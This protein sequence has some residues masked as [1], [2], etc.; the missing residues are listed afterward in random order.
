MPQTHLSAADFRRFLHSSRRVG[1]LV[2]VA[3]VVAVALLAAGAWA[4][5]QA[6]ENHRRTADEALRDQATYLAGMIASGI[7]NNGWFAGRTLLRAWDETLHNGGPWPATDSI[8]ARAAREAIGPDLP[9]LRPTRY[10]AGDAGSWRT[11]TGPAGPSDPVLAAVSRVHDDSMAVDGTF[12]MVVVP[13][14]GDTTVAFA[15]INGHAEHNERWYGFETPLATF[16]QQIITP[17]ITYLAASFRELR[18]SMPQMPVMADS[19]IPLSI[20]IATLDGVPLYRTRTAPAAP[21]MATRWL[22]GGLASQIVL[23]IRPDAVPILIQSG[24]PVRHTAALIGGFL[25]GVVLLALASLLVRRTLALSRQREEFTSSVS[26]ELRTPLTNI[27][28]FAETLLLDRARTADERR[29]ALETITRETRRLVQMVENV[30]AL[31]RV[32]RPA[33]TLVRRPERIEQLV[34]DVIY[35]FDPLLQSRQITADVQ[36]LG[37]ETA[38]VDGDAVRRI[39]VNLIDNAVRYGPVGQR[40]RITATNH[41]GQLELQVEDEGPGV[42]LADRDRVWQPFERGSSAHDSGTGIGLAVVH[43]LVRLHGGTAR[44][45]SGSRG[46]RVVVALPAPQPTS[47]GTT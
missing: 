44:I 29:M 12:R 47:M 43:Q 39:L 21:W 16:R 11:T 7:Q 24:Y 15:M 1:Q 32:G 4:T 38:S 35:S 42:P 19:A 2:T 28:L 26:H 27:Q 45:E 46:A 22:A 41:P 30:L 34:Q 20:S 17:H 37:G 5:W 10:F 3:F 18:D 25:F 13:H 9:D 6:G 40:L 23:S 31:S 36:L 14:G 33:E 8:T